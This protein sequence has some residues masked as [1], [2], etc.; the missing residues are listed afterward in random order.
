MPFMHGTA[1]DIQ[2]L[3]P[4]GSEHYF[5][6][7]VFVVFHMI[8]KSLVLRPLPYPPVASSSAQEL[9]VSV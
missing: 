9:F 1:Q 7:I 2:Q 8:L 3:A 4:T 6:A 5:M